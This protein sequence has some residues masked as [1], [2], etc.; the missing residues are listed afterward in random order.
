MLGIVSWSTTDIFQIL[1]IAAR[2]LKQAQSDS[3]GIFIKIVAYF[4]L[5]ILRRRTKPKKTKA[6]RKAWVHE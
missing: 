1:L 6:I 2:D 5:L 3:L 4:I